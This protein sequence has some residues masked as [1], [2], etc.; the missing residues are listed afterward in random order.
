M[1]HAWYPPQ[2]FV[3]KWEVVTP[4]AVTLVSMIALIIWIEV[5]L[6]HVAQ[7]LFLHYSVELGVDS[8]GSALQVLLLPIAVILAAVIN[9]FLTNL[10]LLSARPLALM[11]AWSTVPLAGLAYWLAWLVL[12]VNGV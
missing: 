9:T 10:L 2:L 6:R 4:L 1:R 8:V 11:V 12:R 3:R 7:P 5:A